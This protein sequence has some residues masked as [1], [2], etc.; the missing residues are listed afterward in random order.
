[1]NE[2]IVYAQ[3]LKALCDR[4]NAVNKETTARTLADVLEN[5][6][7]L[8][9]KEEDGTSY[10]PLAVKE[11]VFHLL[12]PDGYS[13]T[14]VVYDKG[15]EMAS[16]RCVVYADAQG[17]VLGE[18]FA[19]QKRDLTPTFLGGS[20]ADQAVCR[21]AKGR[22]KS[23]AIRDAGILSWFHE[24]TV[25]LMDKAIVEVEKKPEPQP[26]PIDKTA[27]VQQALVMSDSTEEPPKKGT[28]KETA[29]VEPEEYIFQSGSV[30]GR[31]LTDV[32]EKNPEA[33][34]N[35]LKKGRVEENLKKMIIDYVINHD[36]SDPL[37]ILLGKE[38]VQ[39]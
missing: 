30:K 38:N 20:S 22:A 28:P 31:T 8:A 16:A 36:P 14:E 24:D 3:R 11:E 27:Q 2:H 17:K 10:I 29:P 32:C 39:L 4:I 15:M 21:I 12:Y 19:Y 26:E 7:A 5:I 13:N 23:D 6:S 33:I 34:V 35:A 37:R 25:I 1:M 18:G 9:V